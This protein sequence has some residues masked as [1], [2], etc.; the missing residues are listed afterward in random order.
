FLSLMNEKI[1]P[2]KSELSNNRCCFLSL[3]FHQAMKALSGQPHCLTCR[4]NPFSKS[5]CPVHWTIF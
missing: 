5:R 1:I 4:K 3:I 2:K